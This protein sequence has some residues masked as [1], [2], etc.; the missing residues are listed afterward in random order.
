MIKNE[1]VGEYIEG[2]TFRKYLEEEE[3]TPKEKD[4]E[5]NCNMRCFR[6]DS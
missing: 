1:Y 6:S 5:T 3:H 4:G 2:R